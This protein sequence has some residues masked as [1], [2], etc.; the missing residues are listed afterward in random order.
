MRPA[1]RFPLRSMCSHHRGHRYIS[2][3][4]FTKPNLTPF[5]R[6][7]HRALHPIRSHF[8]PHTFITMSFCK[9]CISGMKLLFLRDHEHQ[10]DDPLQVLVTKAHPKV[11]PIILILSHS[12]FKTPTGTYE[13]INGIKT[14]VATPTTD[15]PKNKAILYISDV[16]GLELQNNRV[17]RTRLAIPGLRIFTDEAYSAPSRRFC[18]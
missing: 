15:Y 8:F 3:R 12:Y 2:I 17:R 5:G 10:R 1:M 13:E 4:R 16:F 11:N 9:D 7:L 14:Y 6:P 18:S